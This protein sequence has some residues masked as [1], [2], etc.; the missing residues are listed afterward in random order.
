VAE[1]ETP[2]F[3]SIRGLITGD[4]VRN[5]A[6]DPGRILAAAAANPGVQ[7]VTNFNTTN[8]AYQSGP[9]AFN[10]RAMIGH[11]RPTFRGD[12]NVQFG[13][14]YIEPDAVIDAFNSN[15][16]DM[17]GTNA[18]GYYFMASYYFAKSTWIDG[19]YFSATEV[20]GPPLAIDVLQLELQTRF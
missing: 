13:Y 2:L 15:D 12:W 7:P 10:I 5:L 19:R 16:F 3:G 17:G 1:F 18:K 4:F 6:Y 9:N 14:K 8:N 11:L 20:F